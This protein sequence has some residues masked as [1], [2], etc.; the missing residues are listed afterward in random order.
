MLSINQTITMGDIKRLEE[1]A[2]SLLEIAQMAKTDLGEAI[3]DDDADLYAQHCV[4][5][6][7]EVDDL[8]TSIGD[9]VAD[10]NRND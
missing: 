7:D 5:I 3:A 10:C 8:W 6:E 2:N 4:D 9:W 1:M